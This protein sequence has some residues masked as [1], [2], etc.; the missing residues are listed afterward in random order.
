MYRFPHVSPP[1]MLPLA[2]LRPQIFHS[3]TTII[4]V[5]IGLSAWASRRGFY[6]NFRTSI[7]KIMISYRQNNSEYFPEVKWIHSPVI[8]KTYYRFMMET[9][10]SL[11]FSIESVVTVAMKSFSTC[12]R[13]TL[14]WFVSLRIKVCPKR[15]LRSSLLP[16]VKLVVIYYKID[17]LLEY[18]I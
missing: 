18:Y 3:T 17:G 6:L 8:Y 12:P 14:P 2:S 10:I 5:A 7:L 9:T 13:L 16:G 1:S 15:G 4:Y 11:R